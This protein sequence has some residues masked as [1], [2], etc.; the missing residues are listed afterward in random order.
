MT[1]QVAIVE[2]HRHQRVYC[3]QNFPSFLV[4]GCFFGKFFRDARRLFCYVKGIGQSCPMPF[5]C[6]NIHAQNRFLT[7]GRHKKPRNDNAY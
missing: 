2:R 1:N 7:N 6:L 3:T 5:C 4:A